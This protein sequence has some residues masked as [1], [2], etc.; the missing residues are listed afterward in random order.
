[1]Q[2]VTVPNG[3]SLITARCKPYRFFWATSVEAM[4]TT[5]IAA[6]SNVSC[7]EATGFGW[8][9]YAEFTIA[10]SALLQYADEKQWKL[11][12]AEDIF[13][14]MGSMLG[15]ATLR[16]LNGERVDYIPH[17]LRYEQ[18]YSNGGGVLLVY[19]LDTNRG[20]LHLSHR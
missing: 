4:P 12:P 9:R 1:M 18:K 13:L 19:D 17:G 15:E 11:E 16:E 20:Y 14:S 7:V 3:R 6:A 5:S 8:Y 2:K 10:R